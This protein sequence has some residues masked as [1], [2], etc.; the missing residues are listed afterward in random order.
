V[1]GPNEG[2]SQSV[3]LEELMREE[4]TTTQQRDNDEKLTIDNLWKILSTEKVGAA[5][6]METEK[7]KEL[8]QQ[9]QRSSLQG[10]YE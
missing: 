1:G 3:S 8:S 4:V 10:A 5:P 2:S 6:Q 9:Q 7:L